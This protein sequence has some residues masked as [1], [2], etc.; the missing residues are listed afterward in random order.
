MG[1]V[2]TTQPRPTDTDTD[3]PT[4]S[5]VDE[6]EALL[7]TPGERARTK[8]RTALLDVDRQWL[9]ATSFGCPTPAT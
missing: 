1:P 2:T 3:W 7:G 4:I 9:A 6:L 5:T 8:G